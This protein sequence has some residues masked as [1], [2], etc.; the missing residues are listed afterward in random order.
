[1]LIVHFFVFS[2]FQRNCKRPCKSA[3]FALRINPKLGISIVVAA[4]IIE[5]KTDRRGDGLALWINYIYQHN[6]TCFI[7]LHFPRLRA[8]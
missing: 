8:K 4:A 6:G 2:A 1:M 5:R 7:P 3:I